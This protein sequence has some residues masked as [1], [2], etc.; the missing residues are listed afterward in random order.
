MDYELYVVDDDDRLGINNNLT[1]KHDS[2][3]KNL[4]FRIIIIK[5]SSLPISIIQNI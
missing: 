3:N 1:L 4:I 5:F 2:W